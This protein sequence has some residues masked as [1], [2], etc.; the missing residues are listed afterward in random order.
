MSQ[1]PSQFSPEQ[2]HN[3]YPDGIEEHYWNRARNR[4][5]ADCLGSLPSSNKPI[6]EIGCGRG[7]VV[8]YLRA[9][10]FDCW[11]CDLSPASPISAS[12]TPYLFLG[13]DA[14][15]LPAEA[16]RPFETL[17]FLDVLEH[18]E[19]PE[20]FLQAALDTFPHVRYV[21]VTLPARQE[22]WSNFDYYYNHLRRYSLRQA[23]DLMQSASLAVVRSGYRFHAL[24]LPALVIACLNRKRKV[25]HPRPGSRATRLLH[26]ILSGILCLESNIMPGRLYGT[27]IM[28]VGKRM[29]KRS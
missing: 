20:T 26:A 12:A 1:P 3:A 13:H 5:I 4:L 25:V 21:V 27:S 15:S 6:L 18:V 28:M 8:D 23:R 14:F 17:C 22:L 29:D 10:G 24:Y 7:I 19:H 9:R 16:S 11:G 2:F